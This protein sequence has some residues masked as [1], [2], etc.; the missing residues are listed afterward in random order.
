M[1]LRELGWPRLV[2]APRPLDRGLFSSRSSPALKKNHQKLEFHSETEKLR[3]EEVATRRSSEGDRSFPE[4]LRVLSPRPE[5]DF[6]RPLLYKPKNNTIPS[7]NHYNSISIPQICE[8]STAGLLFAQQPLPGSGCEPLLLACKGDTNLKTV[9]HSHRIDSD[10]S[11]FDLIQSSPDSPI[12]GKTATAIMD[13]N[14]LQPPRPALL[15]GDPC[16]LEAYEIG[17]PLSNVTTRGSN[18]SAGQSSFATGL[19]SLPERG[20]ATKD[21]A[22]GAKTDL[23]PQS[24]IGSEKLAGSSERVPRS[25]NTSNLNATE[26]LQQRTR[27]SHRKRANATDDTNLSNTSSAV[28]PKGPSTSGIKDQQVLSYQPKIPGVPTDQTGFITA[29]STPQPSLTK[30]QKARMNAIKAK[31][32]GQTTIRYTRKI[33]LRKSILSIVLGRQLADTTCRSLK[34]IASAGSAAALVTGAVPEPVTGGA[35]GVAS[36]TQ[37]QA[38]PV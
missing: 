15:Q 26:A 14:N 23:N 32:K 19:Q 31:S 10:P 37:L 13:T 38:A 4:L 20:T 21:F 36:K 28:A 25:L 2:D 9:S 16:G 5:V 6:R 33:V 11:I 8:G 12:G 18:S 27:K 7:S 17:L 3:A 29:P 34:L 35:K 22:P 30:K 24:D 1:K